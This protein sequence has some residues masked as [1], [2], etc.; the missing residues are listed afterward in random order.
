MNINFRIF[1]IEV[2][3][4]SRIRKVTRLS[5]PIPKD[6][7]DAYIRTGIGEW[8]NTFDG[9]PKLVYWSQSKMCFINLPE[10]AK[11]FKKVSLTPRTE[12]IEGKK[13]NT[14]KDRFY[15]VD[16]YFN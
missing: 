16:C 10:K 14:T 4:N 11:E 3:Y 12:I 2:N 7:D 5:I 1:G 13:V 15:V 6:A 9:K 8:N